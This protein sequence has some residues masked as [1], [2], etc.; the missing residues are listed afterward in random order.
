MRSRHKIFSIVIGTAIEYFDNTLFMIF[1]FVISP[2]FFPA[3]NPIT[4]RLLATGT[5]AAGYILRPLGGIF[6]GHIGDRLGRKK[7]LYLSMFVMVIPTFVI[8]ILPT[9][10]QIGLLAPTILIGCRL[11]QNFCIGGE[12]AGGLVSLV[13]HSKPEH[14][15]ITASLLTVGAMLGSLIAVSLGFLFLQPCFSDWGWRVPFLL[16]SIFGLIGLKTRLKFSETHD[17]EQAKKENKLLTQPFFDLI[18][19]NHRELLRTMGMAATYVSIYYTIFVYIVDVLKRDLKIES[20]QI[21]IIN[22]FIILLWLFLIPLMGFISD[23]FERRYMLR[24]ASLCLFLAA[25]PLFYLISSSL[26]LTNIIL[27]EVIFS[28][29]GAAAAAAC[30]PL[31][32]ALY[33]TSKRYSGTAFGWATGVTLFGGLTP[34]FSAQLVVYTNNPVSPAFIL[35]LCGIIGVLSTINV[36]LDNRSFILW[37]KPKEHSRK[38]QFSKRSSVDV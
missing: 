20:R 27:L 11:L 7:S 19:N 14:K 26:N 13:E 22:F 37:S 28:V 33:A 5:F 4:S 21:M 35:M 1:L 3:D 29:I 30:A 36:K 9:Y 12:T 2:L 24:L 38:Q 18:K 17:F 10:Q 23:K 31:V 15:G 32:V 8:G 16:G 34:F 6:F 25:Y